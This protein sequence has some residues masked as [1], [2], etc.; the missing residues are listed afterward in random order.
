MQLN[1]TK[2][3]WGKGMVEGGARK[4]AMSSWHDVVLALKLQ[5]G[6][7]VSGKASSGSGE[8]V[9]VAEAAGGA[10]VGGQPLGVKG[11]SSLVSSIN[12][13]VMLQV[14]LVL[15]LLV[16]A[17]AIFTVSFELRSLRHSSTGFM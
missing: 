4:D 17:W 9:V 14:A 3:T 2:N 1:W 5:A 11:G 12:V 15:A 13:G 7:T 6:T 10:V 16:L 8:A